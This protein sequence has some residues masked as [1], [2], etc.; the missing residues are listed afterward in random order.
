MNRFL[1]LLLALAA[2]SRAEP[3]LPR[4]AQAFQRPAGW[5]LDLDWTVTPAGGVASPTTTRGTLLLARDGRFA[6]AAPGVKAVS[7]GA[8]AWQWS[9]AGNQV[10]LRRSAELD[11]AQTPGAILN[12]ALAGAEKS[13]VEEK[14]GRVA[15][16][17]LELDLSQGPLRRFAGA[18]LWVSVSDLAP[19]KLEV[20]DAQGGSQS[21]NLRSRKA[22][23]PRA[24][25]FAWTN[26]AGAEVVD[27]RN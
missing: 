4:V 14:L 18:R 25:S 5:K 2:V 12:A 11:P 21:W 10:L 19:L 26:P 13:A 22:W 9:E 23:T 15:A 1:A 7:D 24:S 3:W 6:F 16:R 17:R 27:L 8:H 20:R